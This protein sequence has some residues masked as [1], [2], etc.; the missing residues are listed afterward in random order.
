[1]AALP[2]V[3]HSDEDPVV[4]AHD[5]KTSKARQLAGFTFSMNSFVHAGFV[6]QTI[7]RI[8]GLPAGTAFP[9]TDHQQPLIDGVTP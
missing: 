3:S 9:N 7:S 4:P 1:M 2:P 6:R 8:L 5:P